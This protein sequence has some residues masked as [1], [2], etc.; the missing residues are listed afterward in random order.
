[1]VAVTSSPPR[2]WRSAFRTIASAVSVIRFTDTLPDAATPY[3]CPPSDSFALEALRLGS[4]LSSVFA[5]ARVA[6]TTSPS[7]RAE[8]VVFP[9]EPIDPRTF[10]GSSS[11]C[12]FPVATLASRST[13]LAARLAELVESVMVR[14]STTVTK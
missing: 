13:M 4:G 11:A 8:T 2:F 3:F 5:A 7:F 14:A 1:M 9:A 10:A 6:V 12:A